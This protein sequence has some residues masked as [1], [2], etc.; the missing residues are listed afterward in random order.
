MLCVCA[1]SR[2]WG[3]E[4][5]GTA[6][7]S[8]TGGAA[9]G[10]RM[11]REDGIMYSDSSSLSRTSSAAPGLRTGEGLRTKRPQTHKVGVSLFWV[12]SSSLTYLTAR[13]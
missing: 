6:G 13:E 3:C 11:G 12:D 10:G 9:M 2:E 1:V 4:C 8:P 7:I 5:R